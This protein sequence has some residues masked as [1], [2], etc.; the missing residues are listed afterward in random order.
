[1]LALFAL[2]FVIAALVSLGALRED[3][4]QAA[5]DQAV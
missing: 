1:V 4:G 2:T 3:R 5:E